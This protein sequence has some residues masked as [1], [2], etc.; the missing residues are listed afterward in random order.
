MIAEAIKISS[1][2][3]DRDYSLWLEQTIQQLKD[4]FFDEIDLHNLIEELEGMSRSEK[5]AVY[6]NLKIVLT[7]LLKYRYQP[8][9]RS[10]SWRSTIRE[11]RQRLERYFEESPSLRGYF[12]EIFEKSYGDAR[13]LAAD[14]TGLALEAFPAE[15]PF[16]REEAL[17]PEYLPD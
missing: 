3:Y 14:E 12:D 6:S 1:Q 10:N 17:D 5:R 2:L 15:S 8:S 4:G 7:H 13:K 9:K 11:H 16:S